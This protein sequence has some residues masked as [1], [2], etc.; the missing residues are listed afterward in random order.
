MLLHCGKELVYSSFTLWEAVFKGIK[1]INLAGKR[2]FIGSQD[3]RVLYGINGWNIVFIC[4]GCFFHT[5]VYSENWEQKD[6]K[7]FQL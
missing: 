7:D 2:K 5:K 1:V 4:F 6:F 3:F